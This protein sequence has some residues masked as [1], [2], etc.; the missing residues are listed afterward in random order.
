KG[1]CC[2]KG[3]A[4]AE[5]QNDPDRILHPLKRVG[6]PGEFK[7]VS[8]DEALGDI[9]RRLRR[10]RDTYGP[11]SI[12]VHMGNPPYF[13][14]SAVF[15]GK[16]FQDAVGTPWWYGVNS[17]DGASS[18]AATKLLFGAC[19][20]LPIPDY[21]RSDV[22]MVIGANPWVSKGS[23][24]HDPRMRDHMQGVVDRGG[25]VFVVDPRRTETAERF[26][27]V[28]LRAGTDAWFLLS[29]LQVLFSEGL[30]DEDFLARYCTGADEL[31]QE[32][33]RFPPE[34]TEAITGVPAETVR[35]VARAIGG[36]KAA[37]AYGRTGTCTQKFGTLNNVLHQAINVVTGNIQQPGGWVFGWSPIPTAEMSEKMGL[38]TYDEKHTRVSGLPDSFGFLPSSALYDEIMV[39]G[40]GQIRAF[41]M[42]G[43]NSV[44]SGPSGQRLV[45]AL[46]AL[47]TFFAID[48][49]MNET[50]KYAD[51]ILPC[52]T[53]YEREDLP[54]QFLDRMIRPSLMVTEAIT[55]PPGECRP[56]WE[57][58]DDLA[59]RMGLGGAYSNAAQR[60]LAKT[61]RLRIKPRQMA[62]LLLRTGKAGD[63]F[64]LRRSGWSWKK[65]AERAPH[66]VVLHEDLPLR[67]LK[68]RLQHPDKK[69]H[70]AEPR[71][72]AEIARLEREERV[73]VDHPYRLIGLR[74]VRSHNSWM[75]NAE[76]LMPDSR[77]HLLRIHPSDAEALGLA[78]GDEARIT[79]RAGEVVV[80]V[81]LTDE[82]IRG[83]VALPHGWGHNGSWRRA[84]ASGGATS[85]F[86]A[87]S[88][89]EDV[90][91]LSG[92]TVLN[93]I[94]VRIE[95]VSARHPEAAPLAG[96]VPANRGSE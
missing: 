5:V 58:L 6:G 7:R 43:G 95:P 15:W 60:W 53:M 56:E 46:E 54:V 73:D 45:E 16:G 11:K 87:S 69:I 92:S 22:L 37:V 88:R 50:N 82:M 70:L 10:L 2:A 57:I 21:R 90:E 61:L 17:E 32:A 18:V 41:A 19:G 96:T 9:A 27:H 91:A 42:I 66:G 74:E 47:D 80:A 94:P 13:S 44:V 79:S 78:E 93:G 1:F 68:G 89:P 81:T 25:R 48:L 40:D 8:W 84:N 65:L 86:L 72:M 34:A 36:A 75:H 39:P 35:D 59:R 77:R 20:V 3:I 31:R 64:G 85:N 26:E 67:P 24:L 29:V 14:Y 4:M 30:A 23:F 62:D 38:A 55:D 83:T 52:T 76:R 71:V 12:A 28:P 51:Y 49:Y 33:L 63:W